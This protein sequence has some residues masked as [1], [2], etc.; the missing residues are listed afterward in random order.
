MG[1][2]QD[3][4]DPRCRGHPHFAN[5]RLG[6]LALDAIM[7][8]TTEAQCADHKRLRS[9]ENK[10]EG[11]L[12]S[13]KTIKRGNDKI[14]MA[15]HML[16]DEN[17]AL[18]T[19]VEDLMRQIMNQTLTPAPPSPTTDTM[20]SSAVKEMSLQISDI[21]CDIHDVLDVVRNPTGKR[22][23]TPSNSPDETKAKSP[24]TPRKTPQRRRD[25]SP[26]HA[27]MHSRHAATAAQDALDALT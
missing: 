17:T 27:L 8:G 10:M 19:A 11:L 16:R 6:H 14:M 21:Q 18:K 12:Q 2:H 24:T 23:R 5:D 20:T 22:K 15:Y 13:T 9:A 4:Y 7:A 26:T 3:K 25:T 1:S